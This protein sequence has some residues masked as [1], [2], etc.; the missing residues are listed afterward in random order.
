MELTL[1]QKKALD[2]SKHISLTA[3]AGSGK[4]F[5]LSKRYVDIACIENINLNNIV[6]ITFTEK[7]ANELYKRISKEID[8]RY[9][10]LTDNDERRKLGRI[11]RELVSANIST[12]HSFCINI[13]KEYPLEAGIDANFLPID[14]LMSKELIELS[15]T[16]FINKNLSENSNENLKELL[17]V[18]GSKSLFVNKIFGLVEKRKKIIALSE[19]LYVESVEEISKYFNTIFNEFFTEIVNENLEDFI[20][21]MSKINNQ[22]LNDKADNNFALEVFS[23]LVQLKSVIGIT[24]K[25]STLI[26]ITEQAFTK[27]ITIKTRGYLKKQFHEK[28]TDDKE[29][30]ETYL[31]K[32]KTFEI[33]DQREE[34]EKELAHFGKILTE[35]FF[36]INNIYEFKKKQNGYLDFEDLLLLT[37][38]ILLNEN[39]KKKLGEKYKYIMIDEYQDTNE[40]QYEIFMPILNNLLQGN[41]FVVG[42]E[43]QSIY[44]FRDADL[45]LFTRTKNNIN[46]QNNGKGLLKLPHSFRVSPPIALFANKLFEELFKN[47]KLIYNEVEASELICANKEN[48]GEIEIL[49]ADKKEGPNESEFVARRILSLIKKKPETRFSDIAVLCRKRSSF[50][51]LEKKFTEYNIPFTI[52]GGKGFYQQQIVID[53]FN[54][55]SFITNPDNDLALAGLLRSPFFNISDTKLYKVSLVKEKTLWGKLKK[56][57]AEKDEKLKIKIN[58]IHENIFLVSKIE[59]GKVIRKILNESGYW[60]IIADSQN[61]TQD[62]ANLNKLIR[63][64]N[65]YSVQSYKTVFDFIEFLKESM[66]SHSDEGQAAVELGNDAV[67]IMT[68]HQSKG[69]EFKAVFLYNCNDTVESSKIS[70]KNV[71]V[72]SRF[73]ILTKLPPKWNYF[74]KCEAA[75]VVTMADYIEN[76]KEIAEIKRLLY[77]AVTR[78]VNYLFISAI[79]GKNFSKNSFIDLVYKGLKIDPETDYHI[80]T[81]RLKFLKDSNTDTEENLVVRIP[82][83]DSVDTED[84]YKNREDKKTEDFK[85]LSGKIEDHAKREIISASKVAL[86]SQ[87]KRKYEL[88]YEFGY[89]KLFMKFYDLINNFEFNTKEEENAGSL[90]AI[91]GRVIHKILEKEIIFEQFTQI[92][93]QYINEEIGNLVVTEDEKNNLALIITNDLEKYYQSESYQ[94]IKK[95]DEYFNEFEVYSKENE[96][97]LYGIIDKLIFSKNKVLIID[98]KTDDIDFDEVNERG[99]IYL[100]QLQF[101]AYIIS[102]LYPE[103]ETFEVR[104]I[105]IKHPEKNYIKEYTVKEISEFRNIVEEYVNSVKNKTYEKNIKH[106]H[107]CYF[108]LN[109]KMCIYDKVNNRV[110]GG[111]N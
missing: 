46:N 90:G 38:K 29:I 44:K 73:G 97:Y 8:E 53:V 83:K 40:I 3:N 108:F 81:G 6:A 91:K 64:A 105:F 32:I 69:L 84:L 26:R 98:Y 4:T 82:V 11:R 17:R 19:K 66:E 76:K 2:Y 5:I 92:I 106:C 87:C 72:D 18:F 77:V 1:F 96:N 103:K 111:N 20:Y 47:P 62:I 50:D 31:Q 57:S 95:F 59:T 28:L 68:I 94:Y 9:S 35:V 54:Y 45:E 61:A 43:K 86:F 7:A 39:V 60:S 27:D 58:R 55:L 14:P 85:L 34:R 37:K 56:Y 110:L 71:S 63:I 74:L 75:P 25:F 51:G 49:L 67:Q 99:E 100:P 88:T 107:K 13:L 52:M 93:P 48:P 89:S 42:D 65:G 78:A 79:K 70:A 109:K 36:S 102:K 24:E 80:L 16:E 12:I 23:L 33:S 21:S 15:I 41:L 22:V 30:V 10:L 104:L 101:Y